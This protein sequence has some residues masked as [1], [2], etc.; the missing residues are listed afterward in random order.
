MSAARAIDHELELLVGPTHPL[1]AEPS[2]EPHR[3]ARHRIW[4]PGIV[5]GT[6]WGY[7]WPARYGLRRIP[8]RNPTPIYPHSLIWLT[9]NPH[10][11]LAALRDYLAAVRPSQSQ[12]SNVWVPAWAI[13]DSD[14][15]GVV[16]DNAGMHRGRHP[17]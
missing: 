7:L 3:L 9:A 4:I 6:E 15:L 5:P 12:G 1:A 13:A 10:P 11:S 8:L 2:V 17:L 16:I 14:G